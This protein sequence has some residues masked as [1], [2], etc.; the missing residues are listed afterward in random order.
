MTSTIGV[1]KIQYPNGTDIMT[2]DSSG[3]LA[4]ADSA[5]V[6]GT[7]DVTGKVSINNTA[8]PTS[9]YA[10]ELVLTASDEGGMTIVNST[11]HRG[12]LSFADG[13]SGSERYRGYISYDHNTDHLY[14]GAGGSGQIHIDGSGRVTMPL[15]P[16]FLVR[17]NAGNTTNEWQA[18]NVIKFQTVQ[19]NQGSHYSTTTG[20]FTA[21]VAGFYHISFNGFGYIAGAVG[22]TTLTVA[23][24]INGTNFVNWVYESNSA[25]NTYP[26]GTGSA[27]IYLS[28]SDYAQVFVQ[29]GGIYADTTNLYTSFSGHLVC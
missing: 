7:L 9:Y 17:S 23:L 24:N 5:T 3:S 16:H 14:L 13:T 29:S 4:I 21:P 8:S 25:G 2:L 19:V 11:T 10:D 28:A 6:G 22:T 1:K 15:Q 26:S 27:G 20:R 12:Y 18:G